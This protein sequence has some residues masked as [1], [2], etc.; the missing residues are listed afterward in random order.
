MTKTNSYFK[1]LPNGKW[2]VFL[3]YQP[4]VS[5]THVPVQKKDGSIVTIKLGSCIYT[6]PDYATLWTIAR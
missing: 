4:D 6:S 1:R 5:D 2:G 3:G